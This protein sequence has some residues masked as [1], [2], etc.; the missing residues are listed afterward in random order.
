MRFL[1]LL[2][3]GLVGCGSDGGSVDAF[4]LQI[5]SLDVVRPAVDRIE[6]VLRP[7]DLDRHFRTEP[8]D[9][10]QNDVSTRV[11]AAGEFVVLIEKP[12]IDSHFAE[13]PSTFNVRL[14]LFSEESTSDESI[15]D[16]IAYVTF[17]RRDERIALG[18]RAVPWPLPAGEKAD[19]TVRCG[20][21]F[22]RQCTNN[23]GLQTSVDA[24]M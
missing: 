17:I 24:G 10:F 3:I 1:L 23:D 18:E 13:G 19:V 22:S 2:G 9:T 4:T 15:G 6:V 5:N 21:M 11:S 16:P 8:D 12:W 20:A 7:S 14:P